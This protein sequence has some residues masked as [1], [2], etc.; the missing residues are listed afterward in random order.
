MPE[1]YMEE[2][3]K[4]ILEFRKYRV[5]N[6]S[7]VREF[8]SILCAA[9]KGSRGISRVD[10]LMTDQTIPKIMG[11]IPF[12]DWKEWA[13]KRPEWIRGNL[14]TAF[15]AYIERKWKDALNVVAAEHQGWEV[16]TTKK[17][18]GY[19][20]KPAWENHQEKSPLESSGRAPESQARPML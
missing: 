16:D 1:K 19:L 3:L 13:T 17:D 20:E 11:K 10:L 4:P 8:Y 2:A 14:G 18:R 9:K 6:N 5:F 15:K 7:A 12:A